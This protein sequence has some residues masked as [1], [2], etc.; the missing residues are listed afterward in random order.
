[1]C[2]IILYLTVL[3]RHLLLLSAAIPILYHTEMAEAYQ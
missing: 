3:Q 2:L 1:M